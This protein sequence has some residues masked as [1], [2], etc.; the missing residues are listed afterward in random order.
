M[1]EALVLLDFVDP[2]TPSPSTSSFDSSQFQSQQQQ[3]QQSL[4]V[5][6]YSAQAAFKLSDTVYSLAFTILWLFGY[7]RNLA[8]YVVSLGIIPLRTAR[9][10]FG[11]ETHKP[12]PLARPN[13]DKTPASRVSHTSTLLD[14]PSSSSPSSLFAA[15]QDRPDRLLR[16]TRRIGNPQT[17]LPT[18]S[19]S[20]TRT[21]SVP[22]SP[23]LTKGDVALPKLEPETDVEHA[24]SVYTGEPELGRR[25]AN[26]RVR[27]DRGHSM[28]GEL[29]ARHARRKIDHSTRRILFVDPK[30]VRRQTA[31]PA[32]ITSALTSEESVGSNSRA[33]VVTQSPAMEPAE[34]PDIERFEK[35]PSNHSI[36][37]VS[38]SKAS[39]TSS[40]PPSANE[41]GEFVSQPS[42][43]PPTID[44]DNVSCSESISEKKER[45][46]R[47]SFKLFGKKRSSS[48]SSTTRASDVETSQLCP[49]RLRRKSPFPA[50]AADAKTPGVSQSDAETSTHHSSLSI[51]WF[52][53][54]PRRLTRRRSNSLNGSQL[55]A[56]ATPRPSTASETLYKASPTSEPIPPTPASISFLHKSSN[57]HP[58]SLCR[59]STTNSA[60]QTPGRS[61]FNP[62]RDLELHLYTHHGLGT[63]PSNTKEWKATPVPKT[64]I[65]RTN[66]YDLPGVERPVSSSSTSRSDRLREETVMRK[67]D[68]K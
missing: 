60:V 50:R 4:Q 65:K 42:S 33:A 32:P 31:P 46:S 59:S 37:V 21:N 39:P 52:Q 14:P 28:D 13:R 30:Q 36:P 16:T 58:G 23:W 17:P 54:K 19:S 40:R 38:S 6:E 12:V 68:N 29:E 1:S 24:S 44:R 41:F 56:S 51:P 25:S 7:A 45:R 63:G 3:P 57:Q 15:T 2:P 67:R 64:G 5:Q 20:Q 9:Q 43:L 61:R 62:I 48:V 26:N 27:G 22:S 10:I 53:S 11:I 35:V 47:A 8:S 49:R 18:G 34:L 55:P 66:P